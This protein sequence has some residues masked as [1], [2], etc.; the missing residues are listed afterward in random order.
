[1]K[2]SEINQLILSARAC[3]EAHGW[4]LPPRPRWDVTDFGLGDWTKN[5]LVLVNLAEHVEY[6]EKL[7]YARRGMVT[8]AHCHHKKKEDIISRWGTLRIQVWPG[9]PGEEMPE[10]FDILVNGEVRSVSA[11]AEI[12]LAAGERVTLVPNIY[13]SF[14]PV[15]GECII[16]EV[17]TANDDAHDNFF[18]DPDIGRFPHVEEDA[19]AE[20]KLLS[21]PS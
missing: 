4:A 17:S 10:S 21:D 14:V 19:E 15:T 9:R 8:P 12:D 7:M 20:V 18:I 11:G 16:G 5:C 1:M 2:R 3:F 13:H 6:C